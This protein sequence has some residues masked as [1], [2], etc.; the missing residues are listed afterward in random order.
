LP[1]RILSTT[2]GILVVIVLS[3]PDDDK[4]S[5]LTTIYRDH[6]QFLGAYYYVALA[7]LVKAFG[8][9]PDADPIIVLAGPLGFFSLLLAF[10]TLLRLA[11][12]LLELAANP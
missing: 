4:L 5:T 9:R 2:V 1:D 8:V 7:F 6:I 10:P 11:I 12:P 3:L